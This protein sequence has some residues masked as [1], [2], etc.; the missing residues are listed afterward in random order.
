MKHAINNVV[1]QGRAG[2]PTI[3]LSPAGPIFASTELQIDDYPATSVT[4]CG[5]GIDAA[6]IADGEAGDF[7][8]VEGELAYDADKKGFYVFA[9]T[10]RRMT[11]QDSA[12][13]PLPPSMKVFDRFEK[14]FLE[15]EV[16]SRASV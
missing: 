5:I 10:S 14:L 4:V 15:P 12:L 2:P 9:H 3:R 8:H 6:C 13:V 7:L 11:E 1:L 16:A